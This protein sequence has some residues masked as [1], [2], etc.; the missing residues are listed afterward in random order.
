MTKNP[1]HLPQALYGYC[2]GDNLEFRISPALL[3]NTFTGISV[4]LRPTMARLLQYILSHSSERMIEDKD[5]MREVFDNFGLKCN[6]QRLWQAVNALK[7]TLFKCGYSDMDIYRVKNNGFII[8]DIKIGMLILY[9]V[10]DIEITLPLQTP[11][12]KAL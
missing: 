10:K 2:I 1:K 9:S 11:E 4:R 3:V 12:K 7:T 5:I 8:S 6:K